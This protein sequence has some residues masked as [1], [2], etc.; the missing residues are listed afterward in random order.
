MPGTKARRCRWG[1]YTPISSGGTGRLHMH[2]P[3]CRG[4][5]NVALTP[6]ATANS[7]PSGENAAHDSACA[8]CDA[9]DLRVRHVDAALQQP[10]FAPTPRVCV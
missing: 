10:L 6:A 9:T 8:L 7:E 5:H 4:S 2:A 3:L 1:A